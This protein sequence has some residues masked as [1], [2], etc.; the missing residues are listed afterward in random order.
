[1]DPLGN[2]RT[3]VNAVP[4]SGEVRRMF[5]AEQIRHAYLTRD[6]EALSPLLADD[7]RWGDPESPRG[8][9]SRDEVLQIYAAMVEAGVSA[10]IEELSIGEGGI[11][12]A[13]AITWP[14]GLERPGDRFIYHAYMIR[15]GRIDEIRRYDDRRSAA[16]AAGVGG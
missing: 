16:L 12:C 11:L 13:L 5:L 6:L 1:M 7:V 3:N 10:E 4:E 8:C 2:E 9:R 14:P 15:H